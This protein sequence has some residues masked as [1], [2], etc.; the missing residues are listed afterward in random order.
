MKSPSLFSRLGRTRLLAAGLV[1][2]A[3]MLAHGQP[4][5]PEYQ[6]AQG[7]SGLIRSWGSPHMGGL[8]KNW[9]EGFR[10]FHPGIVFADNLKGTASATY[11]FA[12]N[13][14]ELG[15]MGRQIYTFEYYPVYRRSHLLPV[16]IEVATGSLDVPHKSFALAVMVHRDNPL[17][18]LTLRQ[19]D[20]IF[21]AQ[22]E[23]GWQGM[24]WV[25]KAARPAADDIRT[26]GQLGLTGEWADKPIHVYG[27]PGLHP[28]GIS[29]FQRRVMGGS[30][31]WAENLMEFE[32]RAAMMAALSR[33]PLGIAYTGLCYLTT[34]TK[35]LALAEQDGG[36]F[37]APT[38]SSVAD[39][40]YPLSRP[41]Y[42]Y[43]APDTPAGD[44]AVDPKVREFLRYILSRQGQDDV[45]R[46][47]D[48]L[49]LSPAV[50]RAQLDRLEA[51][52]VRIP[53]SH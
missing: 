2:S 50:L 30:D 42:I 7:V 44:P 24:N 14:A 48:Y 49:P 22:R 36:P 38:R 35:A 6:P 26:W 15:L 39:R 19:L 28:G 43:F 52:A 10:K 16:E 27:P 31:R 23:G 32:D 11:G 13:Q 21:G 51:P 1:G 20:G 4:V 34:A 47:G 41:V 53:P 18:Q 33:D 25:K 3:A 17:A 45:A 8:L 5:L 46:E 29:Y 40:T 9:Q 37:V 12:T